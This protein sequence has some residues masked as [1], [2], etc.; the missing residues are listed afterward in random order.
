MAQAP[1]PE[2]GRF[3]P[4]ADR[5]R[6]AA[7]RERRA[8]TIAAAPRGPDNGSGTVFPGGR[9]TLAGRHGASPLRVCGGSQFQ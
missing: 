2:P 9:W 1:A 7:Q 4:H 8:I 6:F 3:G 5:A